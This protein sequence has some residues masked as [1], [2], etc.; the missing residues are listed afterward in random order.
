[1]QKTFIKYTRKLHA[2]IYDYRIRDGKK[3]LLES[4]NGNIAEAYRSLKIMA[5]AL[6]GSGC[7]CIRTSLSM[8]AEYIMDELVYDF[9][10]AYLNPIVSTDIF[11]EEYEKHNGVKLDFSEE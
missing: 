11:V 9:A 1:M 4:C 5:D 8:Q 2:F 7:E 10:K 3:K 6:K